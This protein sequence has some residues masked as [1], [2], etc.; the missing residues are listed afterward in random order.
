[1]KPVAELRAPLHPRQGMDTRSVR[2]CGPITSGPTPHA[3]PPGGLD[4][5]PRPP[6]ATP[7]AWRT[8]CP[9]RPFRARSAALTAGLTLLAV[10]VLANAATLVAPIPVP[11]I[12][13][14]LA[15]SLGGVVAIAASWTGRIWGRWLGAGTSLLTAAGA[16]PGI[17]A[18]VG[19]TQYVAAATVV[20]ALACTVL[21]LLPAAGRGFQAARSER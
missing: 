8:R 15:L 7:T 1:M 14:S 17:G 20:V 13:V 12:V 5:V 18:A 3:A 6:N 9:S 4:A 21:L 2:A 19:P 10:L 16:A 11:V